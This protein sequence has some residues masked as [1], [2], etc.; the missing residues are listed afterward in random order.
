[1]LYP[2][3]KMLE[4]KSSI[5]GGVNDNRFDLSR[6]FLL[7]CPQSEQIV[8]KDQPIVENIVIGHAIGRVM[9][10]LRVFQ[11]NPRLDLR[12]LVLADPGQFEALLPAH[13]TSQ[14]IV[15]SGVRVGCILRLSCTLSSMASTSARISARLSK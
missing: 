15:K 14:R 11:Q 10:P 5:I 6:K 3:F 12:S 1:M 8:A 7:Q 2:I 13:A 9:G 4:G